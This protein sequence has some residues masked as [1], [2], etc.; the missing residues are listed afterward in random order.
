VPAYD[1]ALAAEWERRVLALEPKIFQAQKTRAGQAKWLTLFMSA[2]YLGSEGE[3]AKALA[4]VEKLEGLLNAPGAVPP[5]GAQDPKFNI[6]ALQNSR[7]HWV[8]IR[9]SLRGEQQKLERAILETCKEEPDIGQITTGSKSLYDMLEVLDESLLDALDDA[10]NADTPHKRTASHKEARE[11]TQE[12]T[13]YLNR[14]PL[15]GDIDSNGFTDVKVR[16]SLTESLS[17]LSTNLK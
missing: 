4:I 8:Q 2:Q 17:Y 12:Y 5:A 13:D 6:V 16:A 7:L 9:Q 15:L 1:A 3:F 14:E 11:I 10:L